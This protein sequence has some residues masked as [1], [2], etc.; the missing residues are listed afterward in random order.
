MVAAPGGKH[1]AVRNAVAKHFGTAKADALR[2]EDMSEAKFN[3]LVP[4]STAIVLTLYQLQQ[5]LRPRLTTRSFPM[6]EDMDYA[7]PLDERDLATP[8]SDHDVNH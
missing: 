8:L 6:I 2:P 1:T 4:L 3:H 7:A 5:Q